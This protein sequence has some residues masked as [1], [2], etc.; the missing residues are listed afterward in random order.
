M[1]YPRFSHGPWAESDAHTDVVFGLALE[2]AMAMAIGQA[3]AGGCTCNLML[4]VGDGGFE[5][6][7]DADCPRFRT[8]GGR[9]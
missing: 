8:I 3:I 6:L 4:H 5:V 1:S 9:Q 7:H 2:E